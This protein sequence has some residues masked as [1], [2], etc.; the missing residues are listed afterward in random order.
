MKVYFKDKNCCLIY[1][2][3]FSGD[4]IYYCFVKGYFKD[5]NLFMD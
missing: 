1:F 2:I 5:K 4:E 3:V